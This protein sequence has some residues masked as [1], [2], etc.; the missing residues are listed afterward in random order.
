[1]LSISQFGFDIEINWFAIIFKLE[2]KQCYFDQ[3]FFVSVSKTTTN[4]NSQILIKN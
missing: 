4:S 3:K 2:I 1:V